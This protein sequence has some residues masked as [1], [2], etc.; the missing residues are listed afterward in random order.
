[1]K[2][3]TLK[4]LIHRVQ[5]LFRTI[6]PLYDIINRMRVPFPGTFTII[7]YYHLNYFQLLLLFTVVSV[8]IL[9]TFPYHLMVI[10]L[11]FFYCYT[12]CNVLSQKLFP[13]QFTFYVIKISA[14]SRKKKSFENV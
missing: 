9:N 8:V 5:L 13:Q 12:F 2:M 1:M 6:V 3:T 14:I 11:S 7:V 10:F 4:L